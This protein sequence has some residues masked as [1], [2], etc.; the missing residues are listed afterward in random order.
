MSR[1]IGC[2]H[3]RTTVA[4]DTQPILDYGWWASNGPTAGYLMRLAADATVERCPAHGSAVRLGLGVPRLAAAAP[5]VLPVVSDV[6]ASGIAHNL[7]AFRQGGPFAV[8]S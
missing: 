1:P 7:V 5:Y 6:G 4:P 8:A 2:E 3:G